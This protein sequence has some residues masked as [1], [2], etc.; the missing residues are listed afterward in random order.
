MST[1]ATPVY[2]WNSVPWRKLER[3][4]F[5]LQKRIYQASSRGDVKAVHRLQRLLM[6]SWSARCLAVRRVT[7]DNQGKKT[8][9]I[10]GVKSLTPP[11]RLAL[12]KALSLTQ[13]AQPT[14]RVW[15]PKPG[16]TEKRPLGIPTMSDRAVQ[17][18]AK[19]ALEPEWEAKFEPNSYGFR[20]GRSCHDAIE[21]I[22][23]SIKLKAKYVLDADIAKCFDRINQ[24]KLLA[25]LDTFPT[26]HRIIK[27]WLKSGVMEGGELFPTTEGTPQGGVISPLLANVALHGLE[28]AVTSA[29]P[30]RRG[31][32]SWRPS[33]IRYADDFV[34]LHCDLT[35]VEQAKQLA[36]D[37]LAGM[38]LELKPSKT[39]IVHTLQEHAGER[40]GFDFLGFNVRQYPVG[41]T[42]SGR[43]GG[44]RKNSILLGFKTIIKPSKEAK[45]RHLA[46]IA[47]I[48]RS[49]NPAPQ[50]TLINRLNPIIRGWTNYYSTV[51]SKK[52][53][54][55]MAS[56]TYLK[57]LC[58]A[59][60]RHP[61][62]PG[63]WISRKYWRLEKGG[64]DFGTK[65]GLT[66]YQHWK[67]PIRRHI[68]V[69]GAKSPFDGDW[70][71]WGRR[72]AKHPDA[73]NRIGILLNRQK[74]R[75]AWCGLY[76][77]D[78][79]LLEVDHLVPATLGGAKGYHNW[80]LLHRHCHDQKTAADGSAVCG[81]IHDRSQTVEEPDEGK[82]SCPVLK[83]SRLG[84]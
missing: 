75:C 12:V 80:Q 47:E 27:A 18:L 64:W 51:V 14:R 83:T 38:G 15:I 73:P 31:P 72:L 74:G 5:K 55:T 76:F 70:V 28:I 46:K 36:A 17:A 9:G 62:K 49:H 19:L 43:M 2:E 60:R 54:S 71:Y 7:Q 48:V 65:D 35:V 32:E 41:K 53:F 63:T 81:G 34:I 6:K 4:V 33:V 1:V 77:R 45:K 37:W 58:W 25:K 29:F 59:R 11:K 50:R 56:Q 67:T 13:K 10:D 21:A 68:K 22:F 39:R 61:N 57:L 82:L 42:H 69:R 3:A 8:A 16:A 40:P 24:Q 84:D 78:G 44:R 20:P 52:T 30:Q 23:G 26:L 79:D 66:L